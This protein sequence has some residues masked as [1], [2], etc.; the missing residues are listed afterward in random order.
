MKVDIYSDFV[1]P[2]C[3]IGKTKFQSALEK[4][5]HKDNVQIVYKSFE[6]SPHTSG[7]E[8]TKVTL[9]KKYG[10]SV[11]QAE[12]MTKNV[13]SQASEVGLIFRFDDMRD[14]NTFDAHRLLMLA[15]QQGIASQYVATVFSAYFTYNE[16]IADHQKLTELAVKAGL[17]EEEVTSVLSS[18]QYGDLVRQDEQ[19]ASALG[20]SGVPFFVIN[21]K[22][23]I[24]GAQPE[25]VFLNA[26]QQI[27][28]ET[29]PQ[30]VSFGDDSTG[31]CGPDGCKI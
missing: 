23:A 14:A 19:Q 20:V 27:W 4:F 17:N 3:Y 7:N 29:K 21:D 10:M 15:Q 28:E 5:E 30:L 26:L 6:L 2:F 31:Q 22:Y 13:V 12:E 1:C 9:S 11:E 25:H 8:L 18:D 24:S 16:N